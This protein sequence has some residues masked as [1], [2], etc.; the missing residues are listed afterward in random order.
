MW[1]VVLLLLSLLI[2]FIPA[3]ADPGFDEKYPRDYH[4]FSP[5]NQYALDNPLN[6]AQKYPAPANTPNPRSRFD[7]NNPTNPETRYIPNNPFNPATQFNQDSPLSPA[8]RSNPALP[9][10]PLNRPHE[11]HR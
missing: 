11:S 4:I 7:P 8:N 2:S 6:P 5:A 1:I 10:A 3:L 9:F